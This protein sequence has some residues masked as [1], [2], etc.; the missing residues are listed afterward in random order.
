[1]QTTEPGQ[2]LPAQGTHLLLSAVT[3]QEGCHF[4]ISPDGSG[5]PEAPVGG[6]RPG[7]PYQLVLAGINALKG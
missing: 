7:P 2:T 1:M 5:Q 6:A 3:A 4:A